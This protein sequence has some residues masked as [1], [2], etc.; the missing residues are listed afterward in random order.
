MHLK[1]H[2]KAYHKKN[3]LNKVKLP[4]KRK[5]MEVIPSSRKKSNN[6]VVSKKVKKSDVKIVMTKS[7]VNIFMTNVKI[8]I[9][10]KSI[11]G[12]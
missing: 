4:N 12:L 7:N 8:V 6:N 5:L 3:E 9:L 10:D 2:A 11:S 1:M